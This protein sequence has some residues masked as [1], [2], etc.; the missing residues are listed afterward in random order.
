[1]DGEVDLEKE[2]DKDI[3][4]QVIVAQLN[5]WARSLVNRPDGRLYFNSSKRTRCHQNVGR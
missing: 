4:V 5:T 1:M 2:L 3:D